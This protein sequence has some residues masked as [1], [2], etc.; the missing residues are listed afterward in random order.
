MREASESPEAEP[1]VSARAY[2]H[3]LAAL[4]AR[5]AERWADASAELREAV[6]YDPESPHLH[7]LLA[8]T[9]VRQGLVA[10]A[11]EQLHTALA[12]DP[13][14]APALVLEGRIAAARGDTVAAR[15]AFRAAIAA[16]PRD[17]DAYREL[18]RLEAGQGDVTAAAGVAAQ[19]ESVAQQALREAAAL[20][21]AAGQDLGAVATAGSDAA[22]PAQLLEDDGGEHAWTAQRL[23]ESAGEAWAEVGAAAAQAHDERAAAEAFARAGAI[24]GT[25]P[26]V[27]SAQAE[28]LESRRH[29]VEALAAELKLL[30][31]QPDAP[32]VLASLTRLALEAG[33]AESAAAYARKLVALAAEEDPAADKAAADSTEERRDLA[34]ALLRAGISL[35][36]AQ[37]SG[38]A[39]AAFDGALQLFP[40]HPELR[41]Y[42]ALALSG[43]G[44][45]REAAQLFEQVAADES[46]DSPGA[47]K[48]PQE[49]AVRSFLGSDPAALA[50]DARVQAALARGRAGEGKESVRKLRALFA[51]H[52]LEESVSLALLEALDR[53][54]RAAEALPL[55]A[56]ALREHPRN[57][58]LLYALGS[59]ADRT[60]DKTAALRWMRDLLALAPD[61]ASALNYV[62]YT[63]AESGSA[64]DLDEAERLLAR[65]TLL[66]PVDGAIADSYGFCLLRRGQPARALV[67]LMLADQLSPGDPEILGHLGSAQLAT[68]HRSEAAAT[69]RRALS[70]LAPP[71]SAN[72]REPQPG[73]AKIRAG[74]EARLRSLTVP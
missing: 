6:L 60:G 45:E 74:L 8:D 38:E 64:A 36:S 63:L 29:F 20:E 59:A 10:D 23:R 42:R 61:N 65:A 70:S 12:N 2:D 53:E 35:L 21:R 49:E 41:F 27:I 16:A 34:G 13:Q 26:D 39:L 37:R 9:L 32:E 43:R 44:R 73:D 17:A 11:E 28:Y 55:F 31:Q 67:E 7:T 40:R 72:F 56:A 57:Q 62:G 18:V 15:A 3:Y 69:L 71:A 47:A 54:G 33:D 52:P 30:A 14:H 19:L 5:Q 25:D 66:R 46:S 51:A 24:A 58:A 22:N 68:G 4:L 48:G 50:L 1:S